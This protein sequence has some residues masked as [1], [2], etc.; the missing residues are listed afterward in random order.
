MP[1]GTGSVFWH[2]PIPNHFRHRIGLEDAI[3]FQDLF[4][5][6]GGFA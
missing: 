2:D 4:W 3:Q 5:I 6:K 1:V